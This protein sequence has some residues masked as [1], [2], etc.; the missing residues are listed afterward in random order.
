MIT[1]VIKCDTL[2]EQVAAMVS[3]L[4]DHWSN[5]NWPGTVLCIKFA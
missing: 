3:F 5:L 4:N 2:D 1:M